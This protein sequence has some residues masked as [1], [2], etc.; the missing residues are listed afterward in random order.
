MW[1]LIDMEAEKRFQISQDDKSTTVSASSEL[2]R[3]L[4]RPEVAEIVSGYG[5]GLRRSMDFSSIEIMPPIPR[6]ALERFGD[7]LIKLAGTLDPSPPQAS[8]KIHEIE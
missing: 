1:Y 3:I 7:T 5:S 4:Q 2:G 8:Y 6:D